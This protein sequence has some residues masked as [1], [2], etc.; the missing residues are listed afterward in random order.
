MEREDNRVP[1]FQTDERLED[2]CR[3]WVRD[4]SKTSDNTDRLRNFYDT[5][6]VIILDDA[7]SFQM[8]HVVHD[9]L[10]CEE[11]LCSLVLKNTALRFLDGKLRKRTVMIESSNARLSYYVVDF[12]LVKIGILFQRLLRLSN[13]LI[14][15]FLWF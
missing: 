3:S 11:V 10:A 4:R 14:D 7:D 13:K 5:C 6:N 15:F 2:G 8:A 1:C 9:I 12:F